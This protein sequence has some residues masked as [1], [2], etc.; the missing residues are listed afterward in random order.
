M[1]GNDPVSLKSDNNCNIITLSNLETIQ[2]T[3][4]PTFSG[5]KYVLPSPRVRQG[6]RLEF[7]NLTFNM[8]VPI[9]NTN[10]S[11]DTLS[12]ENQV[13]NNKFLISLPMEPLRDTPEINLVFPYSRAIYANPIF[14]FTAGLN[15]FVLLPLFLLRRVGQ[16]YYFFEFMAI[17][18]SLGWL[19]ELTCEFW[20][21]TFDSDSWIGWSIWL[22]NFIVIALS[23]LFTKYLRNSFGPIFI[24][25]LFFS[26]FPKII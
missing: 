16:Q 15:F 13:K 12:A 14:W 7:D 23:F 18:V 4:I 17:F 26:I 2:Y 11:S 3:T 10:D 20:T 24:C 1:D 19:A 22:I 9:T 5:F 25:K 6:V 21:I 8:H